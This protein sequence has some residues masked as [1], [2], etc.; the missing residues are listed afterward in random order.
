MERRASSPVGEHDH[1]TLA[2]RCP[3]SFV[4][5]RRAWTPVASG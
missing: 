5:V 4:P 3:I 1:R 2:T